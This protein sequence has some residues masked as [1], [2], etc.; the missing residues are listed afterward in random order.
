MP[1]DVVVRERVF[2]ETVG[3]IRLLDVTQVVFDRIDKIAIIELVGITQ[4]K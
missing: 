2:I 4:K 1:C 3:T